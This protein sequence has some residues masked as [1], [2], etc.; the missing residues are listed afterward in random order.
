[1]VVVL[2]LPQRRSLL[3]LSS[4]THFFGIITSP[5]SS[6]SNRNKYGLLLSTII[7]TMYDVVHNGG[8]PFENVVNVVVVAFLGQRA[9]HNISVRDRNISFFEK[10]KSACLHHHHQRSQ[11]ARSKP[12]KTYTTINQLTKPPYVEVERF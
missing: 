8:G 5:S 12:G 2:L 9:R 11:S 7:E 10:A 3:L 6:Q 1:M 4:P